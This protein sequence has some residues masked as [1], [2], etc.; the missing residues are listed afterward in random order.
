MTIK[1]RLLFFFMT[2][3]LL[4]GGMVLAFDHL[5]MRPSFRVAIYMDIALL[6]F[7]SLPFIGFWLNAGKPPSLKQRILAFASPLLLGFMTIAGSLLGHPYIGGALGMGGFL[8]ATVYYH[9]GPRTE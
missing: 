5:I 4:L 7:L 2:M 6:A 9:V 3:Y 8:A 1:S